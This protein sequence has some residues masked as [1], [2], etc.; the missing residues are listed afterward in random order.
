MSEFTHPELPSEDSMFVHPSFMEQRTQSTSLHTQV[1]LN[2]HTVT[3]RNRAGNYTHWPY[4]W[5][6]SE[7]ILDG[8]L[9]EW[10]GTVDKLQSIS[11]M[12]GV[13]FPC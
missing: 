5:N 9:Q 12:A 7:L 8:Y 13:H 10:H 2:T 11:Q 3:N 1:L 4:L 6:E